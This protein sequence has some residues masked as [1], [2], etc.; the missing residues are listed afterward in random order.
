M[1]L[2][3]TGD[4][5]ILGIHFPILVSRFCSTSC[6][7]SL[8]VLPHFLH[9]P[10]QYQ[11]ESE[12]S[13]LDGESAAPRKKKKTRTRKKKSTI[14]DVYEPS[15]LERGHF[16]ERD[17]EIRVTDQPERFQVRSIPVQPPENEAE[18]EQEAEW[19]YEHAFMEMPVSKQVSHLTHAHTRTHAHT[20]TRHAQFP[21]YYPLYSLWYQRRSIAQEPQ[22]GPI[23]GAG[24]NPSRAL[25][26]RSRRP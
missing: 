13:D 11:S 21:S 15:E 20:H 24:G 8:P 1:V 5:H 26:P 19:V 4:A 18:L 9:C 22:G 10:L 12:N 25:S 23:M 6:H 16:L 2:V 14:Y 7:D 17:T 3:H